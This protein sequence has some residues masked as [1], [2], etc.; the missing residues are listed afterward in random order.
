MLWSWQI[1]EE[2]CVP[3]GGEWRKVTL[4][5]ILEAIEEYGKKRYANDCGPSMQKIVDHGD[6]WDAD[7]VFQIAMYGDVIYG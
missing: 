6:F 2:G 1:R 5:K 7:A 3:E 4:E